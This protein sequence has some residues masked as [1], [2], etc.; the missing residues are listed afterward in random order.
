MAKPK[1]TKSKSAGKPRAASVQQLAK[2]GPKRFAPAQEAEVRRLAA[3]EVGKVAPAILKTAN[4]N[5]QNIVNG[6][7]GNMMEFFS[8]IYEEGLDLAEVADGKKPAAPVADVIRVFRL[9]LS[10]RVK[11]DTREAEKR[12]RAAGLLPTPA[13]APA[14]DAKPARKS[15]AK[16]RSKKS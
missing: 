4:Q 3:E 16:P 12:L 7:G 14:A 2:P 8:E 6:S 1:T 9:G 13:N 10:A 15:A 5:A 11:R